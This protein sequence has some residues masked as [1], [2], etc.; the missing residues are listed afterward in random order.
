MASNFSIH[1]RY[2]KA[3]LFVTICSLL[4]TLPGIASA[5]LTQMLLDS[6]IGKGK[7][8]WLRPI[9]S[10]MVLLM[11]FQYLLT[12]LSGMFSRK[13]QMGISAKMHSRFFRHLLDLPYH[14]YSQRFVGDVVSRTGL[15]DSMVGFI[16]GQLTGAIVSV[17]TMLLFGMVLFAYNP[18]LT[19]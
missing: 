1:K 15:V 2:R 18:L 9:L 16:T 5:A 10:S 3:L 12:E 6:V 14:F 11:I 17:I 7:V 19:L 8:D 4:A 13:M